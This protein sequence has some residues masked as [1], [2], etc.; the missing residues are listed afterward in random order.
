MTDLV[1]RLRNPFC[2]TAQDSAEAAN[3]IERLSQVLENFQQARVLQG[4]AITDASNEIARLRAALLLIR[5]M[6]PMTVDDQRWRIAKDALE[7]K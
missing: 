6:G 5:D 4:K 7:G 1:E 3:E 2:V